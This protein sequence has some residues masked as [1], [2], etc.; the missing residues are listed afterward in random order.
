MHRIVPTIF[1]SSMNQIW[2]NLKHSD[3]S[4]YSILCPTVPLDLGPS[5][6]VWKDWSEAQYI[7]HL[8]HCR[9]WTETLVRRS[10]DR[11]T[12]THMLRP[13]LANPFSDFSPW[14]MAWQQV[15]KSWDLRRRSL[16]NPTQ[17]S[18]AGALPWYYATSSVVYCPTVVVCIVQC[19]LYNHSVVSI[20]VVSST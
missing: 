20:S 11:K 17:P 8:V 10:E 7:V 4:G 14:P 15:W 16:F 6:I 13:L 9:L 2:Q 18:P 3:I 1:K 12:K 19:T 5:V